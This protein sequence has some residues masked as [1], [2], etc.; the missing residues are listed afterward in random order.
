MSDLNIRLLLHRLWRTWR[1]SGYEQD[2]PKSYVFMFEP[3][4]VQ[5]GVLGQWG[6]TVVAEEGDAP[7]EALITFLSKLADD[8]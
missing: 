3:H 5:K 1:S 2:R 6:I 7:E 8:T 4:P